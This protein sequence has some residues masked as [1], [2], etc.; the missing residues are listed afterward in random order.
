V[1]NGP[2]FFYF[3]NE[4]NVELYVDNSGL[5]WQNAE[6]FGA[7]LVFAEHRFYGHSHLDD[8]CSMAHLTTEQALA[9][10]AVVIEAFRKELKP[11]AVIGFGGSY[12]GHLATMFRFDYPHLVEGVI[13]A[14]APMLA[15]LDMDPPYDSSSYAR[16]VT[17]NAGPECAAAVKSGF[18]TMFN[19]AQNSTGRSTLASTFKTCKALKDKN[20]AMNL[21]SWAQVCDYLRLFSFRQGTHYFA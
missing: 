9:D 16:V 20:D 11:S 2:I 12:G 15:Y 13:A 18:K 3:G 1:P 10:F 7:A 4:A 8:D 5:M 21:L 19:L 14:S 6:K 17:K